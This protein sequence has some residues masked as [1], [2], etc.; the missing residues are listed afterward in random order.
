MK[1]LIRSAS[2]AAAVLVLAACYEG[3]AVTDPDPPVGTSFSEDVNPI[4]AVGG[5]TASGCHGSGAGEL[6]LTPSAAANY[7]SLVNVP[8]SSAS[9]FLL[10]EPSNSQDSYVVMKLEGRQ[11][12]GARMPLGGALSSSQITTIRAWIDAGAPDN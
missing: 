9:T 7:A 6:T 10:V 3:D 11:T 8:A 12:S 4:F 1:R 2:R 5:C